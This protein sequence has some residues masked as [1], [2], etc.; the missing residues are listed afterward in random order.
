MPDH[1][2]ISQLRRRK[3]KNSNL[4]VDIFDEIV[5]KCIDTK[6]CLLSACALN[7]K[8]LVRHLKSVRFNGAVHLINIMFQ[9]FS[10]SSVLMAYFFVF[11]NSSKKGVIFL[12]NLAL[13][14]I[15][16]GIY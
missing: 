4:F 7:L 15:T 3:F 5:R 13:F 6:Q 12:V 16:I 14:E 1:S 9:F 2:T 10:K 11:A 8:R